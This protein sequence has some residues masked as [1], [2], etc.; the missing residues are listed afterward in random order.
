MWCSDTNFPFQLCSIRAK[1]YNSTTLVHV[2]AGSH[3]RVAVPE[4]LLVGTVKNIPP[5]GTFRLRICL[6]L[7]E[8]IRKLSH[9]HIGKLAFL[10]QLTIISHTVLIRLLKKFIGC[11]PASHLIKP[12]GS[13][14]H[15]VVSIS[16][17]I[18]FKVAILIN[19]VIKIR[20]FPCLCIIDHTAKHILG[21]GSEVGAVSVITCQQISGKVR[22]G[23]DAAVLSFICCR[24]M[25]VLFAGNPRIPWTAI[26]KRIPGIIAGM[27]CLGSFLP[28]GSYR[29]LYHGIFF[30]DIVDQFCIHVIGACR[31]RI[32]AEN[33]TKLSKHV[34]HDRLLVLHREHPDTEILC[35]IFFSELLTGQSQKGKGNLIT[36]LFMMLLCNGNCFFIKKT[37]IGH[38]NGCFQTILMRRLLLKFE[39]IKRLGKQ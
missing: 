27:I 6:F 3:I 29:T 14:K 33:I 23:Y 1:I 22:N 36:V 5:E 17:I 31:F 12:A 21:M 13:Y 10:L 28:A 26:H 11:F 24:C 37:C 39:N 7:T 30:F 18:L 2:D 38:L 32:K 35:L 16:V 25:D 20:E 19:Q 4:Q 9:G 34:I 15:H 8:V